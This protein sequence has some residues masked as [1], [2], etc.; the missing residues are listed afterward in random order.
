MRRCSPA[1]AVGAP[2]E[3]EAVAKVKARYLPMDPSSE[4]VKRMKA[5][6]DAAYVAK[7]PGGI[8]IGVPEDQYLMHL[9]TVLVAREDISEAAIYEITKTIY[10]RNAE[11]LK[12]P[13][14]MES[15]NE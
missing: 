13:G 1:L 11:V 5:V 4:A 15:H 8:F 6:I 12:R 10:D 14:L 7:V 3:A 2:I 9:D